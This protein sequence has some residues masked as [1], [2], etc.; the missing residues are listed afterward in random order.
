MKMRAMLR[1]RKRKWRNKREK[2]RKMRGRL[3][4]TKIEFPKMR[5]T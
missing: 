5:H 2:E 1:G 3:K 4:K